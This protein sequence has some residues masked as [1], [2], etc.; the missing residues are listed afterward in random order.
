MLPAFFIDPRM[1]CFFLVV[2]AGLMASFTD[3]L[4]A[5]EQEQSQLSQHAADLYE[6]GYFEEYAVNMSRSI[7]D[8]VLQLTEEQEDTTFAEIIADN[9]EPASVQQAM[10]RS[11]ARNYRNEPGAE[12][13]G[14]L[15]QPHIQVLMGHL[16]ASEVDLEEAE[17]RASFEAYAARME[18]AAETED[19][20]T[21]P[22]RQ[23]I[24]LVAEI[25]QAT[26]RIPLTVQGLE[27]ML[28]IVIFAIN[29]SKP[30]AEQL[31][32][33]E[34]NDLLLSL[35]A[36]FRAFFEDILLYVSLFSTR[37]QS[38]GSLQEHLDFLRSES[39]QWFVRTYNNA[40][41]DSFN[42]RGDAVSEALAQWA[43]TRISTQ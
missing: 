23:R 26:R 4:N 6:L 39:G 9:F 36:N 43:V 20:E 41:L 38:L 27:E 18:R 34:L 24:A 7:R 2:L 37:N 15:N 16:Y 33:E 30:S 17:T 42:E 21:E 12:S 32:D 29:Q 14:H 10:R 8:I 3:S 40:I 11:L 13:I 22:A 25:L 1:S 35:R 31:S 28:A 5:Q 19:P